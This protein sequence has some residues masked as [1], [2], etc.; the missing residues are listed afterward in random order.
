MLGDL[1]VDPE[2]GSDVLV[3]HR[4]PLTGPHG[5]APGPDVEAIAWFRTTAK[6]IARDARR[7]APVLNQTVGD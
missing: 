2:D 6:P 1:L 4:L 5:I 7:S 3:H